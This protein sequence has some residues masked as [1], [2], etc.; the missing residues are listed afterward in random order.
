MDKKD[1]IL[2]VILC[3]I[4]CTGMLAYPCAFL[5]FQWM[6]E[7]AQWTGLAPLPP[8]PIV[9]YLARSL[10]FFYGMISTI[11]LVCS[12]DIDRYR[13]LIRIFGALAFVLGIFLLVYDATSG[14]PRWWTIVEGVPTMVAGGLIWWLAGGSAP[15][16]FA[17]RI[18]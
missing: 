7:I 18:D 17:Q 16:N 13:K 6:D 12:T 4:G 8:D 1:R 14:M 2:R 5:P 3:V 10:S 11:V 9:G 15:Q